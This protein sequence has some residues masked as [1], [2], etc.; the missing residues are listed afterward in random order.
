MVNALH[1]SRPNADLDRQ[2]LAELLRTTILIVV[3][4][5]GAFVIFFGGRGLTSAQNQADRAQAQTFTLAQQVASAC[6]MK[7]PAT[8]ALGGICQE[9]AP[10]VKAGPAGQPGPAGDPGSVGIE[11]PLGPKGV[12]GPRGPQGVQGVTGLQGIFGKQGTTGIPGTTG[13]AGTIGGTGPTGLDGPKG[14]EGPAGPAG[15]AG[16]AGQT[17]T[18]MTCTP[19][20]LPATTST[21]TVTAWK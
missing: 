6:A 1:S 15:A 2:G 14:A 17:P 4:I 11:G 3:M 8:D 9:V 19:D 7:S 21:C 20:P 18:Q 10:I 13:D 12:S 5:L 16:T